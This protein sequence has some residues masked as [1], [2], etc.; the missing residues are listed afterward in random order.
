MVELR[1]SSRGINKVRVALPR[2]TEAI[3]ISA[4]PKPPKEAS[5]LPRWIP[6]NS[7]SSS[8]P[9]PQDRNGSMRSNS[10]V[11]ACL[12]ASTAVGRNC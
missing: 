7:A 3:K 5:P 6:P 1:V 8:R 10:T 12:R 11:S 2:A 4:S 9:L